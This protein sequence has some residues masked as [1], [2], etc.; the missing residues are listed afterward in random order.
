MTSPEVLVVVTGLL[1][2][3]E[4]AGTLLD[5]VTG[6]I[7]IEVRT[8]QLVTSGGQLVTVIVLVV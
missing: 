2:G 5:V 6:Y 1:V 7:V 8:G 4:T 3:N